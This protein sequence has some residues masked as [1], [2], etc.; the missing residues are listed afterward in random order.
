[1]TSIQIEN[2]KFQYPSAK[3]PALNTTSFKIK[4]GE[5][6]GILGASGGVTSAKAAIIKIKR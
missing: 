6:F 4:D 5:A 3:E 2:L 1:M